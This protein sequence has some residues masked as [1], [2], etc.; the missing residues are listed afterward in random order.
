LRLEDDAQSRLQNRVNSWQTALYT[1]LAADE[2]NEPRAPDFSDPTFPDNNGRRLDEIR[3]N[4]TQPST[5]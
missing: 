5:T 2:W 4:P 1:A 3:L